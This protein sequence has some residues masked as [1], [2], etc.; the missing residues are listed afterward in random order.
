MAYVAEPHSAAFEELKEAVVNCN[1]CNP[2]EVEDV[3]SVAKSNPHLLYFSR[4]ALPSRDVPVSLV[5]YAMH[6]GKQHLASSLSE[7]RQ[8]DR[9]V[10]VQMVKTNA[11]VESIQHFFQVAEG[12][13]DDLITTYS[14]DNE[15]DMFC[16]LHIAAKSSPST[17]KAL[18]PFVR[19]DTRTLEARTGALCILLGK[20]NISLIGALFE[21]DKSEAFRQA[22]RAAW[23]RVTDNWHYYD[24]DKR[25]DFDVFRFLIIHL[26]LPKGLV[27][28]GDQ[29]KRDLVKSLTRK[30]SRDDDSD[31][32]YYYGCLCVSEAACF[33]RYEWGDEN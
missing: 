13:R 30:R 25:L 16:V 11:P 14:F 32:D 21:H 27:Y 22:A 19:P 33:C 23:V 20:N 26:G 7:I 12:H 3:C 6:L 17:F 5:A 1:D 2:G 29:E 4:I 24:E 10:L 15:N 18:L 28:D 9:D 31:D 8:A